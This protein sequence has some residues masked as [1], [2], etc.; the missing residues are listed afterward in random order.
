MSVVTTY[1]SGDS[2]TVYR[3]FASGGVA[4]DPSEVSV[5]IEDPAGNIST[6]TFGVDSEVV[7]D[8]VGSYSC[9]VVVNESGWWRYRW[10]SGGD[11]ISVERHRFYVEY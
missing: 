2:V 1:Q 10:V 9:A 6:Y 11:Y 3:T 5:E 4:L 8:E 7:N